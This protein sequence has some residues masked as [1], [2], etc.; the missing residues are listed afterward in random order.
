MISNFKLKYFFYTNNKKFHQIFYIY[1][2]NFSS[3]KIN[4][5]HDSLLTQGT[6]KEEELDNTSFHTED[7]ENAEISEFLAK[8]GW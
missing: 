4:N 2:F 1:N 8:P 6:E 7:E 5:R 3:I